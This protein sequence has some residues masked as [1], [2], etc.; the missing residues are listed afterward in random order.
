[1]CLHIY[2]YMCMHACMHI[3][4]IERFVFKCQIPCKTQYADYLIYCNQNFGATSIYDLNLNVQILYV[5]EF[6]W[7]P[8]VHVTYFAYEATL[9]NP[10]QHLQ[11]Q[12]VLYPTKFRAS[13]LLRFS[14]I[15]GILG[16][17]DLGQVV[18]RMQPKAVQGTG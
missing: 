4:F 9:R 13:F 1:M 3:Q 8:I 2:T 7:F 12:K 11:P 15:V 5:T 10:A 6:K 18:Q 14:M 17:D 16:L